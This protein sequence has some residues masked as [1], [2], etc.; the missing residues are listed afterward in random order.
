MVYFG[1]GASDIAFKRIFLI[2]PRKLSM[3]RKFDI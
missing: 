1:L 2:L 3:I